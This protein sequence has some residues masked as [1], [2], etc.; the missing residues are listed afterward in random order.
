MTNY[1]YERGK[2][3]HLIDL[4]KFTLSSKPET[5]EFNLIV[6]YIMIR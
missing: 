5:Y 4:K 3:T 1:A 2:N 6:F